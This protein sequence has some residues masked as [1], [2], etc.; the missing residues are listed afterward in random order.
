MSS[1]MDTHALLV[2]GSWCCCDHPTLPRQCQ[3]GKGHAWNCV[4]FTGRTFAEISELNWISPFRLQN[5]LS[6]LFLYSSAGRAGQSLVAWLAATRP[7]ISRHCD[8]KP[9]GKWPM[10]NCFRSCGGSRFL[11]GDASDSFSVRLGAMQELLQSCQA[12]SH[13][14]GPTARFGPTAR[15]DAGVAWSKETFETHPF[16]Q[17][18]A[19]MPGIAAV[20]SWYHW[21]TRVRPIESFRCVCVC[22]CA[23]VRGCVFLV[24]SLQ[25][26]GLTQTRLEVASRSLTLGTEPTLPTPSLQQGAVEVLCGPM[27][28]PTLIGFVRDQHGFTRSGFEWHRNQPPAAVS[29][30]LSSNVQR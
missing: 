10:R 18:A 12:S 6:A 3:R 30:A 23:C 11:S 8:A 5:G 9:R 27:S 4:V 13:G 14:R 2:S 16:C 22:V 25:S 20:Q 29:L 15:P 17:Y 21:R 26:V 19:L 1:H 7:G 24:F 28:K